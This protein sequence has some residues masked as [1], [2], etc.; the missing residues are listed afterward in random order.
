MCSLCMIFRFLLVVKSLVVV[1]EIWV[2]CS[3]GGRKWITV[4]I[5]F[6][7]FLS[8]VDICIFLKCRC[9]QK[10]KNDEF[11]CA[12]RPKKKKKT[13][14]ACV[15]LFFQLCLLFKNICLYECMYVISSPVGGL[16][17]THP[18]AC[19]CKHLGVWFTYLVFFGIF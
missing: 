6:T 10:T 17:I 2:P 5:I 13:L 14:F 8:N 19:L 12:K 7:Q 4:K 3:Y 15:F 18:Q 9:S 11:W 1:Q 16:N